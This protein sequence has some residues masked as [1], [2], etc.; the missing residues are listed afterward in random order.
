[1]KD[2]ILRGNINVSVCTVNQLSMDF[3]NNENRI[4]KAIEIAKKSSKI[5]L[6]PELVTTGYSCQTKFHEDETYTLSMNILR[7]ICNHQTL[8]KDIL[9]VLGAP[10]IY[11]KIKYNAMIF[12]S[13]GIIQLIR[14]KI[15][16]ANDGKYSESNWFTS[17]T[18]KGLKNYQLIGFN[19]QNSTKIGIAI[20]NCNGVKIAAEICAE[21]WVSKSMNIQLYLNNTDI[22]LNSSG[23]YF[24][25]NKIKKR[26]SLVNNATKR[27]GGAYVY[28]NMKGC[29]GEFYYFDGGSFIGL[30]G[31]IIGIQERFTLIDIEVLTCTINLDDITNYRKDLSTQMQSYKVEKIDIIKID[32]DL[33]SSNIIDSSNKKISNNFLAILN[34]NSKEVSLFQRKYKL[35]TDISDREIAEVCEASACWLW[36][37]LKRSNAIGFILQLNGDLDSAIVSLLVKIMCDKIYKYWDYI[38]NDIQYEIVK[39]LKKYLPSKI[40]SKEICKIILKT[41]YLPIKENSFNEYKQIKNSASYRRSR[42]IAAY[43]GAEWLSEDITEIYIAVKTI[44]DV[45][46]KEKMKKLKNIN[47][48]SKNLINNTNNYKIKPRYRLSDENLQSYLRTVINYLLSFSINKSGVLLTLDCYNADEDVI[49]HYEQYDFALKNLNPIGSMPA[50]FV[51]KALEY[52]SL[53]WNSLEYADVLITIPVNELT[54]EDTITLTHNQIYYFSKL[55]SQG[56]GIR[57]MF[58]YIVENLNKKNIK[59]FIIP[60]STIENEELNTFHKI[61][62]YIAKKI[63]YFFTR[64]IKNSNKTI[65]LTPSIHLL[66]S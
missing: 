57:S 31:T 38:K 25:M 5:I 49:S 35:I 50:Q 7:N 27:F 60:E 9:L 20:I 64:Y 53:L 41:I 8:T 55:H 32:L 42:D 29:D 39:K 11:N 46:M 51:N 65:I 23:S 18:K 1:M 54:N 17:W 28:S 62:I 43:I 36:D 10:I 34:R 13:N 14:P 33:K 48:N 6:L 15:N 59:T 24:E 12:I 40:N 47:I 16:L 2:N 37:Y 58:N 22:I 26:I 44:L 45:N 19:Q 61:K 3:L 30:N 4:I 63:K 56:Y 52:Y 21:L 66:P